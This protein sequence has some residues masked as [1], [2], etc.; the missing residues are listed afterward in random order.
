M[1]TPMVGRILTHLHR[2]GELGAPRPRAISVRRAR[3]PRPYAVRKPQDYV[4]TAP[5]DLVPLDT[6]DVRPLPGVTLKPLAARDMISRWDVFEV[7][8]RATAS[9]AARFLDERAAETLK[10]GWPEVPSWVFCSESGTLLDLSHVTKAW[11]RVLKQAKLPSFRL[12]P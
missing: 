7:A 8:S 2:R 1:S 9:T 4:V 6:L 11:R 12:L 10:R 3:P 5:R